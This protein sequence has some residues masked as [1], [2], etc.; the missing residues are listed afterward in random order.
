MLRSMSHPH[1]HAPLK[2]LVAYDGSADADAAVE[3]V[4][5]AFPGARAT[6][7]SV[8]EPLIVDDL[9]PTLPEEATQAVARRAAERARSLG[10]EAEPGWQAGVTDVWRAIVDAA[11]R[12]QAD[13]IVTGRRGLAGHRSSPEGSVAQGVVRHAGRPVLVVPSAQPAQPRRAAAAARAVGN[14][15]LRIQV[16]CLEEV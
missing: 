1:D 13:L 10:L 11:A 6:V 14:G 8:W 15:G 5:A 7:L 9:R 4:A 2:I 3:L 12:E 16:A